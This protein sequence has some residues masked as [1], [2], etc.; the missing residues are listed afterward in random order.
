MSEDVTCMTERLLSVTM[1]SMETPEVDHQRPATRQGY[2]EVSSLLTDTTASAY[3]HAPNPLSSDGTA[4]TSSHSR[5]WNTKGNVVVLRE[6]RFLETAPAAILTVIV[7]TGR[8]TPADW[9]TG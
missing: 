5:G 4:G 1:S 8:V 6:S 2:G 9:T 7:I 3:R